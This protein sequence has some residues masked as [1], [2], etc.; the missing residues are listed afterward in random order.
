[1]P[2][3]KLVLII[4]ILFCS[5]PHIHYTFDFI[6]HMY[7]I[8]QIHFLIMSQKLLLRLP[9]YKIFL[10]LFF[11]YQWAFLPFQ[12]FGIINNI[13]KI[14][15]RIC[16]SS[17]RLFPLHKC[18]EVRTGA[19]RVRAI[20][21]ITYSC[22]RKLLNHNPQQYRDTGFTETSFFSVLDVKESFPVHPLS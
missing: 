14:I 13:S 11:L 17:L 6:S 20:C 8:S 16:I 9:M 22:Q 10:R 2:S 7:L 1:M 19:N 15:F 3:P 5:Y 21:H 18:S 12:L 4:Y